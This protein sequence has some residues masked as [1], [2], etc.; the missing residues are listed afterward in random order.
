MLANPP[1]VNIE[2]LKDTFEICD[3]VVFS[4]GHNQLPRVQ[5]T[6]EGHSLEL[7]LHGAHITSYMQA[8][9]EVLW[10]SESSH[11][12]AEKAIRGGIPLCWPWFGPHESRNDRPQHGFARASQFRVVNTE[13]NAL[14]TGIILR[15][16]ADQAPYEEWQGKATLEVEIRLSDTLWMELR[17]IN[18]SESPLLASQAIHSYFQVE[19][20]RKIA[21]PELTGLKYH[22][23][24]NDNQVTEQKDPILLNGEVDRVYLNTP[25]RVTLH[26]QISDRCIAIDTWGNAHFVVWNPGESNAKAMGDFDDDGYE[27][28]V[29]IEP[30]NAQV[31]PV[32]INPGETHR[33]GQLLTHL[34]IEQ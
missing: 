20:S 15:L 29:C 1:I 25:R 4:A 3:K 18:H 30:A 23:K 7:Y 6:F 5:L 22:D 8:G 14:Y 11:F 16:D 10:L 34:A 2:S 27:H 12:N 26:D 32:S 28:M 33:I 17:T 13:S 24:V 19:D 21:I 31:S 9:E